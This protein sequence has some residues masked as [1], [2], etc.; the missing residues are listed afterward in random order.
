VIVSTW[1]GTPRDRHG[2]HQ[3]SGVA[4][5]AAFDAAADPARFPELASEEGLE[6]WTPL[7]LVRST[8]FDTTETTVSLPTGALDPWLG[9]SYHQIA[10]ASRS[11]HR[12]QDMGQVQ[13]IGPRRT[14]LRLLR[15][16]TDPATDGSGEDGLFAGIPADTSGFARFARQIRRVLDP[17]SAAELTPRIAAELQRARSASESDSEQVDL[18]EQALMI[19]AG[20]VIDAVASDDEVVPEQAV[21]VTVN[22]YNGGPHEVSLDSIAVLTPPG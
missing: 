17:T 16:R 13:A 10:M 5:I 7:K 11:R 9:R 4:A 21:N 14:R 1:S 3:A 2:Q 20:V 6:A 22:V 12:S 18:L 15:D 8:R 19:S